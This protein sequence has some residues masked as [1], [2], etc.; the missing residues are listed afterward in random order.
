[1]ECWSVATLSG[2]YP[3]ITVNVLCVLTSLK[4]QSK[5]FFKSCASS[6]G[7]P[8]KTDTNHDKSQRSEIAFSIKLLEYLKIL[9]D[10]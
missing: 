8:Y 10:I 7:T 6:L 3:V 2:R 1:M 4:S 5:S 9:D